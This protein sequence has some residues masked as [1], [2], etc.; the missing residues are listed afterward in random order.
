MRRRRQE[1]GHDF[2]EPEE[3]RGWAVYR[4]TTYKTT[5]K[6]RLMLAALLVLA[7][8]ATRGWWIGAA[9]RGLVSE[10][11]PCKPDVILVD[12]LV[13]DYKLFE[14]A[15]ALMKLNSARMALVP[16]RSSDKDP[17]KPDLLA[18]EITQIMIR[19]ARLPRCRLLP[20]RQVEPFTLSVARRVGRFVESHRDIHSVLIV[21]EALRSRRTM[22]VYGR[23]LGKLGV[24]ACTY[25]V[26]EA[27]RPGGWAATWHGRQE[28]V[29]QYLKLI[30]YEFLLFRMSKD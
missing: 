27:G 24:A 22:L 3:W 19:Q 23:V 20:F 21:T 26:W 16:V 9:G 17:G 7:T 13:S 29:L 6:L 1:V 14:K 8:F 30:Y 5:W 18:G 10:P 28:V 25:P 12:N 11:G 4:T 15:G 2:I